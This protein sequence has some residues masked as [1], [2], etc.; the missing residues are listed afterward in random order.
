[1]QVLAASAP[2]L[3]QAMA[4]ATAKAYVVMDGTLLRI[5]RVAMASG[6]DRAY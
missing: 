4:V 2:T 1:L 5:D 3:E 6:R